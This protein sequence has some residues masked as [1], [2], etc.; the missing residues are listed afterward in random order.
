MN[1]KTVF[2]PF[3]K[4]DE[5]K[6]FITG[7]VSSIIIFTILYSLRFRTDSIFHYTY[8]QSVESLGAV[9]LSTIAVYATAIVVFFIFGKAINKKTRII[10]ITN[11]V[12]ISQI[13][14][15]FAAVPSQLNFIQDSG[16]HFLAGLELGSKIEPVALMTV[17]SFSL[18]SLALSAY[19]ITLLY[20]GFKTATNL[21]DWVYIVIFAILLIILVLLVQ[22]LN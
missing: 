2:N 4:F 11:A 7:I 8:I 5:K 9:I 6:L 3:L 10:D 19:G 1:W 18:Y 12:L 13:P 20:N 17:I 15:I 22:F 16:K 14:G 21:K